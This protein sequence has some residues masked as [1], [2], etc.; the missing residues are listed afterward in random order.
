MDNQ[1]QREGDFEQSHL[2][3]IKRAIEDIQKNLGSISLDQLMQELETIKM[4]ISNIK[5]E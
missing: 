5:D 2:E 3:I 4:W 1:K